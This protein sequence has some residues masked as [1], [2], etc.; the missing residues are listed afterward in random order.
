VL[1]EASLVSK[2]SG[3]VLALPGDGC[4]I[5]SPRGSEVLVI[6]N[7]RAGDRFWPAHAKAPRKLKELLQSRHITGAV[8]KLW[9]VI[10][11][12]GEVIWVRG[13]GVERNFRAT[14]GEGVLIYATNLR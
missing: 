7:W 5:A 3:T 9:P 12:G 6:R 2:P 14:G 8:K 13:M 10:A 1:I 11:S 4:L